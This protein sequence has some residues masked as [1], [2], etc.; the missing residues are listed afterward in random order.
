MPPAPPGE[1]ERARKG[2]FEALV[3][4][5]CEGLEGP[6]QDALGADVDPRAGGH[7]TVHRQAQVLEP[8]ELRPYRPV[9]NK[10]AVGQDHPRRPLMR[11]QNADRPT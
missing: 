3:G 11:P 9:A 7:L 4:Y 1:R 8:A 6:L 5:G 10:V 2:A